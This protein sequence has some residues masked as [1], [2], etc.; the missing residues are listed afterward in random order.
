[1][2]LPIKPFQ[3]RS[4]WVHKQVLPKHTAMDSHTVY[5]KDGCRLA[6]TQFIRR[7]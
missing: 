4:I 6:H 2:T 3:L 7:R 5:A 1:M